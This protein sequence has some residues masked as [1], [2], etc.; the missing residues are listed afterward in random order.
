MRFEKGTPRHSC[1]YYT[2]VSGVRDDGRFFSR[3]RLLWQFCYILILFPWLWAPGFGWGLSL[4]PQPFVMAFY[5]LPIIFSTLLN[6]DFVQI[7]YKVHR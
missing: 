3:V 2:N 1:T 5:H 6:L 4:L 7:S